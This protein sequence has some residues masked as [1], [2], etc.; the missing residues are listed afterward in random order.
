MFFKRLKTNS[1]QKFL[2]TVLNSR[3]KEF[4]SGKIVS[5]GIIFDYNN[6]QDYDFFK[7]ML[8]DLGISVNRIRFIS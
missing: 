4:K 7:I 8:T 3:L 1:S 6:F 2:T 5:V